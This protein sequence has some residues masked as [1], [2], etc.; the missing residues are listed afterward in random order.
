M[1]VQKHLSSAASLPL[2]CPAASL[3]CNN[4]RP[5]GYRTEER[6]R[7]LH[8]CCATSACHVT[9]LLQGAAIACNTTATTSSF[10]AMTITKLLCETACGAG[11]KLPHEG[12][13]VCW[14]FL[15]SRPPAPRQRGWRYT[16]NITRQC[17]QRD[18]SCSRAGTWQQVVTAWCAITAAATLA[19]AAASATTAAAAAGCQRMALVRWGGQQLVQ[20]VKLAA[21]PIDTS[22][23]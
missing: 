15:H 1:M 23:R 18:I 5:V 17:G 8:E 10:A 6:A 9:L 4:R 12:S 13:Q 20:K 14:H 21:Q 19:A 3:L 2:L 22:C 16:D 11:S 7:W